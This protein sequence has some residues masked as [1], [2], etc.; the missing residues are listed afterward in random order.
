MLLFRLPVTSTQKLLQ[1]VRCSLWLAFAFQETKKGQ[2]TAK[3]PSSDVD[4]DADDATAI[5]AEFENE[6]YDNDLEV[7]PGPQQTRWTFFWLLIQL[8]CLLI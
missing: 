4:D 8:H 5:M 1:L 3:P 7:D 6:M 2:K